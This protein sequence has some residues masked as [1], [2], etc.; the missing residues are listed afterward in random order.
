MIAEHLLAKNVSRNPLNGISEKSTD[1][2]DRFSW[3]APLAFWAFPFFL[4]RTWHSC[5]EAQWRLGDPKEGPQPG[6]GR[7]GGEQKPGPLITYFCEGYTSSEK[8][9]SRPLVI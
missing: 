8:P 5:M 6:D 9:I 3:C 1:F 7:A 2:L 4:S